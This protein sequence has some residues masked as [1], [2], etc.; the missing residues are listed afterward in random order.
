M[1]GKGINVQGIDVNLSA[2]DLINS[3]KA[4]FSEPD[5]DQLLKEVI[6]S[7]NLKADTEFKPTDVF[8]ITV[9]TP[10]FDDKSPDL[11]FIKAAVSKMSPY[12]EPGNLVILE[13]TSP[14]GTTEKI[15][16]WLNEQRPELNI[17]DSIR[18]GTPSIHFAYCPERVLPGKILK[19]LRE[20]N[21]I[22]GGM[23][24]SCS[25]K[26]IEFYKLFVDGQLQNTDA[27]TAE[28]VKLTENSFRDVNIAF[29]NELSIISDKHGIDVWELIEL[30][31]LHP[32]VDILQPG[33]GVGGHCIAVDPWFIVNSNP[34]SSKIICAARE[35]NDT[36]P[37]YVTKKS[38]ESIHSLRSKNITCFGITFKPDIDDLR[39]SPAVQVVQELQKQLGFTIKI[40]EPNINKLPDFLEEDKFKLVD[41]AA[42][43]SESDLGVFLVK[44]K[45]FTELSFNHLKDLQVLDFVNVFG[46]F[47][48]DSPNYRF[49]N[50]LPSSDHCSVKSYFFDESDIFG[51]F[52]S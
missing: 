13:S 17:I 18:H 14:V 9:P 50:G 22:I 30:A 47:R 32:R 16:S 42:G 48:V 43:I 1:L 19:E 51:H 44:H 21:R 20:N 35:I 7:G 12:L 2:V 38:L 10:I 36:K 24:E 41:L 37:N 49:I 3:G 5:L 39:G 45:E 4:H 31:N 40:V 46:N 33:I 15:A 28:M 52:S 25:Q 27:R 34:R 11:S 8:I 23:T 29:A 6:K 26:A